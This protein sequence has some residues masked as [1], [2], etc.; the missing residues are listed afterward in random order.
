[1]GVVV[2]GC[3]LS[4]SVDLVDDLIGNSAGLSEYLSALYYSVTYRGDL[5]HRVN[6]LCVAC[7]EYLN[8]LFKSLGM[9]GEIAVS[10]IASAVACLSADVTADAY[11]VT[12][13]LCDD[14]F[15]SHIKKL[16]FE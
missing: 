3:Q 12:V 9:C 11:S 7:G 8:E 4:E 2:N 5:V 13:A 15:V 6:D 16:I 14:R 1:M 10:L